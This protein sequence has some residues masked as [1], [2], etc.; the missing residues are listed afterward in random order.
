MRFGTVK[1][2]GG[3]KIAENHFRRMLVDKK[4]GAERHWGMQ[5]LHKVRLHIKFAM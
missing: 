3:L 5:V 1:I 4:S 2:P